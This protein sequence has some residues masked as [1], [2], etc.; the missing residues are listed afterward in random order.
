[1]DRSDA[2]GCTGCLVDRIRFVY[3]ARG[4]PKVQADRR[5]QSRS[6]APNGSKYKALR[7]DDVNSSQ[8]GS[9]E[10]ATADSSVERSQGSDRQ[11]RKVIYIWQ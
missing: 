6:K 5:V 3:V 7:G 10:G 4:G 1:M 8:T 9:N 11:Y 2:W